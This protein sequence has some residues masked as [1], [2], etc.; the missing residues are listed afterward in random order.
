MRARRIQEF[1]LEGAG[2]YFLFSPPSLPHSLPS[3][4]FPPLS[5]RNRFSL[6]QPEGL[7]S[8]V[9]SPSRVRMKTKL[10]HSKAVR[11]PLVAII[12]SAC[13]AV[14]RSK[15]STSVP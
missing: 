15:F 3:F 12:L 13:F 5:F 6:K 14:K 2:P 1:A 8:G 7:R 9:N 4:P 10:V 11:K